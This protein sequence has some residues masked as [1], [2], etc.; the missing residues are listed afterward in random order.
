M[1]QS[2]QKY[3][4]IRHWDYWWEVYSCGRDWAGPQGAEFSLTD[5][6]GGEAPFFHL[7]LYNLS[8]LADIIR[9][10]TF[11]EAGDPEYPRFVRRAESLQKG[12]ADYF[13]GALYYHQFTPDLAFCNQPLTPEVL[14]HWLTKLSTPLFIFCMTMK[15]VWSQGRFTRVVAMEE[16]AILM[17]IGQPRISNTAK[18]PNNTRAVIAIFILIYPPP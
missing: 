10:E 17:E 12:E 3:I 15:L 1:K 14:N 6:R 18:T 5:G 13:V 9:E 4:Q 7:D 11:F 8:G 2:S 16:I